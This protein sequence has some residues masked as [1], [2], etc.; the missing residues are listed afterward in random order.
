M[1][2]WI[3]LP[4]ISALLMASVN[5]VG[6][7]FVLEG[8]DNLDFKSFC[9]YSGGMQIV[10]FVLLFLFSPIEL[11]KF[12][13]TDSLIVLMSGIFFGLSL[14]FLVKAMDIEEISRVE[15]IYLIH[16]ILVPLIGLFY[17]NENI[18]F[19][20]YIG[21]ILIFISSIFASVRWEKNLKSIDKTAISSL[22]IGGIFFA[23]A[24]IIMKESIDKNLFTDPQ[25]LS[26]RALGLFFAAGIPFMNKKNF[27]NLST[28]FTHKRR[29]TALFVFE[30]IFPLVSMYLIVVS[31]NYIEISIVNSFNGARPIFTILFS[32]FIAYILQ[33][34]TQEK[35]DSINIFIKFISGI[36]ALLGIILLA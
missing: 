3:L 29:G 33:R 35:L 32:I 19:D 22:V 28:F 27:R 31:L 18:T 30:T 9:L 20:K 14:I 10:I 15:P 16:T 5:V 7:F 2:L 4:L 1:E 23:I 34:N 17:L 11:N 12:I 25:I 6:K 13:S 24:S 21:I 26:L 8:D 36:L